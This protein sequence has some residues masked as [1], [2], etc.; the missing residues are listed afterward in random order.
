MA[1]SGPIPLDHLVEASRQA[2]LDEMEIARR[3]I[4]AEIAAGDLT[5]LNEGRGRVGRGRRLD[6][7][8]VAL[9]RAIK[10]LH[11]RRRKGECL[12]VYAPRKARAIVQEAAR[13]AG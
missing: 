2:L 7:E 4:A 11:T 3:A 12:R 8:A 6:L 9:A 5:S 13:T 10:A 1:N